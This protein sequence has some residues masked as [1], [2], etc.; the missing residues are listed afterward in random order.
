MPVDLA[1]IQAIPAQPGSYVLVLRLEPGREITVGRLGKFDFPSGFY[2]YVGSAN[3]PGGLRG[4]V[5]RH[6]R[7]DTKSH[8][9]IDALRG[10]A[11]LAE[12]WWAE[13]PAR[14]EC[15][16]AEILSAWA[17]RHAPHFGASDCGCA[18]HLCRA[19]VQ[20]EI[21]QSWAALRDQEPSPLQRA[22]ARKHQIVTT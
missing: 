9:H 5:G 12:I 13:S 17:P 14:D 10:V 6:L 18:G 2:L 15:R 22:W 16:W 21:D 1:L 8:W 11:R 19:G 3:G 7:A 4:R 20:R